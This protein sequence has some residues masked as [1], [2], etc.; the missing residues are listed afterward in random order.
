MRVEWGA[1]TE[2]DLKLPNYGQLCGELRILRTV[3]RINSSPHNYFF[4]EITEL[5]SKI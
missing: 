5:Q 3:R 2:D 1:N 4:Y